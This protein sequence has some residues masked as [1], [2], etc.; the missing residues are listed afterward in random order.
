MNRDVLDRLLQEVSP[1]NELAEG[2]S[3]FEDQT[4]VFTGKLPELSRSEAT[5]IIEAEGG[6]VTSSVSGVTD[7]L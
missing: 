7:L 6:R 2:G 4:V 1:T 3:A 5:E